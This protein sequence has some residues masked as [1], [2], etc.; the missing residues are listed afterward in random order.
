MTINGVRNLNEQRFELSADTNLFFGLN[1]SGKTSILESI[2][3]LSTGRSFRTHSARSL[4]HHDADHCL[5]HGHLIRADC[6][7]NLGIRRHRSGD[8]ELRIDGAAARSLAELAKLIPTV[9]IDSNSIDIIAGAPEFRRRYLDGTVF[10]VEQNFLSQWR[11]YHRLLK[12]RNAGLRRGTLSSD[13]LWVNELAK[14]GEALTATRTKMIDVLATRFVS[15]AGVLS[16]ALSTVDIS[17]R[18]GWDASIGLLEAIQKSELSDRSHGFTHI[19]PHRADLRVTLNG[20]P[21]VDVMSRGQMKLAIIAM[22]LAQGQLL[23][24][25][26]GAPPIYLVDDIMAELDEH[27]ASNVLKILAKIRAQFFLTAVRSEGIQCFW[28]NRRLK[29]FHVEQGQI[30]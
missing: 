7:H 25:Q 17:L 18:R 4:I 24:E 20:K 13:R 10:H 22:K 12:Q 16:P 1:G 8:V 3:L 23:A 29:M 28:P 19:G 14:A 11:D 21:A 26:G 30:K 9:L 27:H 15:T 2:S 6:Q 5:V